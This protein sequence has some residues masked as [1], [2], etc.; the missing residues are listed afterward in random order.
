MLK[1]S[2]EMSKE[3]REIHIK[4]LGRKRAETKYRNKLKMIEVLKRC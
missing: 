4:N 1:Y 2:Y 3:E